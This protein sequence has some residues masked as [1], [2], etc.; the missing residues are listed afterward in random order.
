MCEREVSNRNL[1]SDTVVERKSELPGIYTDLAHFFPLQERLRLKCGGLKMPNDTNEERYKKA[2]DFLREKF[3]KIS[4]D[5]RRR[6]LGLVDIEAGSYRSG[7]LNP[8]PDRRDELRIDELPYEPDS[9]MNY[10]FRISAYPVPNILYEIGQYARGGYNVR[11]EHSRGPFNPA[12]NVMQGNAASFLNWLSEFSGLE[13]RLPVEAEWNRA[14]M[15]L[16][17][18]KEYLYGSDKQ[19][20]SAAHTFDPENYKTLSLI[21]L[22]ERFPERKIQMGGNTWDITEVS[23]ESA[24]A[25]Y[26]DKKGN[27]NGYLYHAKGGG[28]QHCSLGPRQALSMTCDPALRSPSVGFRF[29]EAQNPFENHYGGWRRGTNA[30]AGKPLFKESSEFPSTIK[31]TQ[32]KNTE[33][34]FISHNGR[35]AQKIEPKMAN[36]DTHFI[37]ANKFLLESGED[38]VQLEHVL[39]A[40]A[41]MEVWNVLIRIDGAYAPPTAEFSALDYTK[42]IRE[43]HFLQGATRAIAVKNNIEMKFKDSVYETNSLKADEYCSYSVEIDFPSNRFIGRQSAVFNFGKDDFEKDI[44]PARSFATKIHNKESWG[45]MV[46]NELYNLPNFEDAGKSPMLVALKNGWVTPLRFE[47]EPARHKL[48]DFMGDLALLGIPLVGSIKAI[49]PGHKNNFLFVQ[50]IAK[51]ITENDPS[52]EIV[53]LR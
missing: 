40:L 33:G 23:L 10:P 11:C 36:N 39:A 27:I 17:G 49:R 12:V 21:E 52:F 41:G 24:S 42:L 8:I 30:I 29:V 5:E 38:L 47:N 26:F 34:L 1:K 4:L 7:T 6:Y 18:G 16:S 46:E 15:V 3:L 14:A 45:K 2:L 13:L 31:F 25:T 53:K 28:F 20:R 35:S 9:S 51:R 22:Q 48:L 32:T 50:E 19:I 44:A 37:R 43:G